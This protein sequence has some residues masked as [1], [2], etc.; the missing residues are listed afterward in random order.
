MD[1]GLITP[2]KINAIIL[3]YDEKDFAEKCHTIKKNGNGQQA[4]LLEKEYAQ[5]SLRRKIFFRKL[6]VKLKDNSMILFHNIEFGTELFT[7]LAILRI[8]DQ[9]M[10]S[11]RLTGWCMRFAGVR[12]LEPLIRCRLPAPVDF[13]ST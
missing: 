1:K 9:V 3:N 7:A 11:D 13:A 4:Y 10:T 5:K 2:V 8:A 12:F 6:I